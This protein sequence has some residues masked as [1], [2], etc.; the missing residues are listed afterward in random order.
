MQMFLCCV[1]LTSI[2]AC[3]CSP[4]NKTTTFKSPKDMAMLGQMLKKCLSPITT[5]GKIQLC[6]NR[7]PCAFSHWKQHDCCCFLGSCYKQKQQDSSCFLGSCYKQNNMIVVLFWVVSYKR[8]LELSLSL[9]WASSTIK[10]SMAVSRYPCCLLMACRIR[11]IWFQCLQ[12]RVW[13]NCILSSQLRW[14][15]RKSS[16]SSSLL[17]LFYNM[18]T[19]NNRVCA[20]QSFF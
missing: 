15:S 12:L 18:I 8:E 14:S 6:K 19:K 4:T 10:R 2:P 17:Y 13:I 9:L 7:A 20:M 11:R 16:N 1:S 5:R 3:R